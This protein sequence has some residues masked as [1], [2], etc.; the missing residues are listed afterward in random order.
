M[1]VKD[2]VKLE[3]INIKGDDI[4]DINEKWIQ[5]YIVSEPSVL[6][7]GNLVVR[8]TEIIQPNAGRLDILLQDSENDLIYEVEVQL[9]KTNESHIIRTIE[10]WDI[11]RKRYPQYNHYAVIIAEELTSRFFNIVQL[12]NG[13]VPLIAIQMKAYK[14]NGKI[15]ITFTKILDK[16]D[17]I[18]EPPDPPSNKDEWVKR[19]SIESVEMTSSVCDIVNEIESGF[20]LIYQKSLIILSK[21]GTPHTRFVRMFPHKSF[22]RIV[23]LSDRNEDID[24]IIDK[25]EFDTLEYNDRRGRYI[26]KI[27]TKE[28][29]NKKET[30]KLLLEK[31]YEQ[32]FDK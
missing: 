7:L 27:T 26:L 6:G 23:C 18:V 8:A 17:A 30:I 12:F 24:T 4:P 10:Y 9:G 19:S 2:L 31:V 14:V 1:D 16:I 5:D 13:F 20:S 3:P 11:E 22:L 29:S 15:G 21:N 32:Y 25:N 28:F